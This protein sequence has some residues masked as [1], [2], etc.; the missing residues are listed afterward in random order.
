MMNILIVDD[1]APLRYALN[2]MIQHVLPHQTTIHEA[3]GVQSGLEALKRK[4]FDLVFLD[5]EMGDGTGF[6]LVA[7]IE[8]PTFQLVFVTAHQHY[9]IDAFRYSAIDYLLKPVDI[10][11][12]RRSLQRAEEH[13]SHRVRLEQLAVLREGLEPK[14][15]HQKRIVLRD[16]EAIHYI[17]VADIVFLEA[18]TGY[19]KFFLTEGKSI[20]VSKTMKEYEDILLP[21]GFIRT[22]HSYMVN[23]NYIIR[24]DKADGGSIITEDGSIVP[25]SQ[26]KR[27]NI[28]KLLSAM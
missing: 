17:K 6:D 25:V 28:L 21:Y 12:L 15:Y 18:Q 1:E 5:V 26:R 2:T 16:H 3:D 23:S 22:H 7:Q 11:D 24:F 27:E 9:A 13:I 14:S 8:N 19:T 20:L 4:D 10:D